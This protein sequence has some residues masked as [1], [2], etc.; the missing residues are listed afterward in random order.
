MRRV[1]RKP[2]RRSTAVIGIPLV[3]RSH[4][5]C[6]IATEG[7]QLPRRRDIGHVGSV[8]EF[9]ARGPDSP[10]DG[11]GAARRPLLSSLAHADVAQLVEHNLAKV[12]V[13]GSNPVVRSIYV[14]LRPQTGARAMPASPTPSLDTRPR[15][16]GDGGTGARAVTWWRTVAIVVVALAVGAVGGYLLG[17]ADDEDGPAAASTSTTTLATTTS[18]VVSSTTTTA[19]VT[20]TTEAAPAS[21]VS[22]YTDADPSH[23]R[24]SDTEPERNLQVRVFDDS[25]YQIVADFPVTMNG[26]GTRQTAVRWRSLGRP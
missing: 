22:Q 5:W 17:S 11:V 14:G 2:C 26:C 13:A 24:P 12:G 20:T 9:D 3:R 1:R 4:G 7:T 8:H 19:P 23:W 25:A 15:W 10:S 16:T 18:T 21:L 6:R